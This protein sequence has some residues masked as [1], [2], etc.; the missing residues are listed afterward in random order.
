MS[1]RFTGKAIP[2]GVSLPD[3][4]WA[5]LDLRAEAED[6]SVS[7]II[8]RAIESDIFAQAECAQDGE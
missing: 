3:D 8:R 6:R 1:Q 2:K 7:A 4:M 5:Y